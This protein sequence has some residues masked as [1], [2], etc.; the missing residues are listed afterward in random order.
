MR[1]LDHADK[2]GALSQIVLLE[3]PLDEGDSSDLSGVPVRVAADESAHC[4]EDAVRR[5]GQGYTAVALKPIAK[6]LSMT[7]RILKAAYQLSL[8]HI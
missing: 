4:A 1:F 6:T 7:F 5:I 2:I 3:E 8:I